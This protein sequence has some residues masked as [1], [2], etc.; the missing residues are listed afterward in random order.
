MI[1]WLY[2]KKIFHELNFGLKTKI[3]LL[4]NGRK[5]TGMRIPGCFNPLCDFSLFYNSESEK[6]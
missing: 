1:G 6:A 3:E 2:R 5:P 4:V